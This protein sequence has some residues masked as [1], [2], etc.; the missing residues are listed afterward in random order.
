MGGNG[1]KLGFVFWTL[2][3][4]TLLAITVGDTTLARALALWGSLWVLPAAVLVVL[5][6]RAAARERRL[7]RRRIPVGRRPPLGRRLRQ[8]LFNLHTLRGRSEERRVGKE[9][10]SRVA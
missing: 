1:A 8:T 9:H 5:W 3:C 6:R 4:F 10:T 7:T 2:I